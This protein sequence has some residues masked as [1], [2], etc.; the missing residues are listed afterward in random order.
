MSN[1]QGIPPQ[2]HN[3]MPEGFSWVGLA[4]VALANLFIFVVLVLSIAQ[5]LIN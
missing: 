1:L 3:E 5:R 4:I 2:T